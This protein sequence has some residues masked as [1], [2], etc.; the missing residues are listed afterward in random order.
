MHWS[1]MNDA[2]R[3]SWMIASLGAGSLTGRGLTQ[4]GSLQTH[5]GASLGETMLYRLMKA[6]Q[7]RFYESLSRSKHHSLDILNI[8]AENIAK[9]I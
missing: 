6:V 4:G 2:D 3:G 8:D 1:R 9:C 5:S 7:L